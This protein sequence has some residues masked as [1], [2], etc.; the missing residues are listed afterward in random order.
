MTNLFYPSLAI[1]LSKRFPPPSSDS[2]FAQ[3]RTGPSRAT[4]REH[5]LSIL[6]TRL[7]DSFFPYPPPL[8]P[9]LAW[10][11]WWDDTPPDPEDGAWFLDR[12]DGEMEWLEEEV[13]VM[14]IAWADVG[15]VL[16]GPGAS[17]RSWAQRD[18][19]IL[20]ILREMAEGWE[21]SGG[22]QRCVRSLEDQRCM[23]FSPDELD[24]EA[25]QHIQLPPAA[26]LR[27]EDI[28][29]GVVVPF[30]VPRG[31]LLE[32]ERR[33]AEGMGALGGVAQAELFG[34]ARVTG[35]GADNSGA[36]LLTVS[37]TIS[38]LA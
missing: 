19:T 14:R 16:D 8:L 6:T 10:T 3:P 34:E 37:V 38:E 32:F 2:P 18:H 24:E 30:H 5:P 13:R 1:Y 31:E 11:G 23:L 9:R 17:E 29:R 21:E 26:K 33:W 36:W 27:T 35:R 22:G 7:L 15:D 12:P 20:G 28:Y 4:P 25:V